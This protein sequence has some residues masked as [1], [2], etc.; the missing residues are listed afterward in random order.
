LD[1]YLRS[2][3]MLLR[4]EEWGICSTGSFSNFHRCLHYLKP[5]KLLCFRTICLHIDLG[6]DKIE[7]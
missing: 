7:L 1:G 2:G 3:E 6:A 5:F 4:A